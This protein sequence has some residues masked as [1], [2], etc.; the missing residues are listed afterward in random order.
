MMARMNVE[1]VILGE[2]EILP[3]TTLLTSQWVMQR[4]ARFFDQPDRFM[5]E[6]WLDGLE[7]RL[8][9]GAYFPFGDGP[10]RCIGQGFAQLETSLVIATIAQKFRFRLKKGFPVVPEPLVTLRPKYGIEMTIE[11][12]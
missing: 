6:R 11:P 4:D 9:P 7:Q 5:P 1:T 12:R 3:G 2:Y 10:R 8:P